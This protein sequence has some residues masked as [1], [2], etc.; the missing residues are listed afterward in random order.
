MAVKKPAG[1][2]PLKGAMAKAGKLKG[3]K[4]S[5]KSM[6]S[7]EPDLK[8]FLGVRT[9]AQS[10]A[11]GRLKVAAGKGKAKKASAL[12]S[13]LGRIKKKKAQKGGTLNFG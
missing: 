7:N 1:F 4:Y 9:T 13:M 5:K 10:A 6:S 3:L 12:K 11:E 2:N 8:Q